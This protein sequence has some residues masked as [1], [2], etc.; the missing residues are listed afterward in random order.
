MTIE[1]ILSFWVGVKYEKKGVSSINFRVSLKFFSIKELIA[2][3]KVVLSIYHRN[4]AFVALIEAD[5]GEEYN[6]ASSPNPSPECKLFLTLPSI[7]TA[8]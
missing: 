4:D 2:L 3:L 5:L 1:A 6:K 8:S 7:S